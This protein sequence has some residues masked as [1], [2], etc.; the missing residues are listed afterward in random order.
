MTTL[1]EKDLALNWHPCSQM[2]DY[3]TLKTMVVKS[4]QGSYIELEDGRRIIDAI[5]SWWCKSLGHQHPY[6]KEALKA[7][8]DQF[9]HVMFA[10]TTYENVVRLSEKLTGLTKT[11]HKVM[12]AGDGSCA[13]EIALKMS[14]HAQQL[15][16]RPHRTRFVALENAYHGETALALSVS[17][18]GIYRA[19]YQSLLQHYNFIK[20]VPYV[21]GKDDPRWNDCSAEWPLIEAQLEAEKN[22]LSAII[23]EPI[24]QGA[25]GMLIYS[26]DFLRRLRSWTIKN[27]VHLIADEIMVG[28]GRAGLPIACHYA[29]IEPDFL[30]LS[31]SL[32]AGFLPLSA[33]LTRDDIYQLFYDDYEMGKSFLHSHT[34]SGNA[35][36]VTAALAT[37]EV[38]RNEH[39]Y[40][41]LLGLETKLTMLM[42]EVMDETGLL[43]NLR[44]IGG[45]VAADLINPQKKPRLGFQVFQE[46]VKLGALLRPLG[47]TVYWMPPLTVDDETLLTL[48]N[49]TRDVI[50][51]KGS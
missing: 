19:P 34:H 14:V 44:S 37:F 31:K 4:S 17:D 22:T 24:V 12:Y 50:L 6:I 32:T 46:A 43:Y 38:M 51:T 25:G 39:I 13:V 41:R 20:N 49:M 5:S 11:L 42:R 47:N 7:Q 36:A 26:Q 3:E 15:L 40:E 28:L 9:E 16:G 21:S 29:D 35:L 33:M 23:L 48:K 1:I 30:C 18:L 10:N 27:N 2:K 45:M 8:L